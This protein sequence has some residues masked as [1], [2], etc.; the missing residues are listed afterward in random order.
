MT[1][2]L[3][4]RKNNFYLDI[5]FLGF[6][7][8]FTFWKVGLWD[9]GLFLNIYVSNSCVRF[10]FDV[11]MVGGDQTFGNCKTLRTC[12]VASFCSAEVHWCSDRYAAVA[13]GHRLHTQISFQ[14]TDLLASEFLSVA[15]KQSSNTSEMIEIRVFSLSSNYYQ[16]RSVAS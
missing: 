13:K 10:I 7:L 12:Q 14:L 11:C 9:F 2:I 5:T 6:I 1:K 15:P 4:S 8:E 16:L 3:R